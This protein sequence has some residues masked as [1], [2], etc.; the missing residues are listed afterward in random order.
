LA[1]QRAIPVIGEVFSKTREGN[2]L[3][4]HIDT[5]REN[6][7]EH[8]LQNFTGLM[9]HHQTMAATKYMSRWIEA[10]NS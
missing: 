4:K 1:Q 9:L 3:V 2:R 8:R 10:K 5:L 6:L 7:E